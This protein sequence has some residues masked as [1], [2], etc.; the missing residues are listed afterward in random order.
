MPPHPSLSHPAQQR[1]IAARVAVVTPV[2]SA[3]WGRMNSLEMLCHLTEAFRLVLKERPT[4]RRRSLLRNAAGRYLALRSPLP[5][6][7][8]YPTLPALDMKRTGVPDV[9]FEDK[10]NE[11]VAL[12]VRFSAAT[13]KELLAEHPI[14]GPMTFEEWM[15]WGYRHTDHHLRQF[16]C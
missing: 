16:S 3:R 9:G 12:L 6:A 1:Q 5:W 10:R 4:S 7:H 8:G 2:S 13:P 15:I 11:L 14:F